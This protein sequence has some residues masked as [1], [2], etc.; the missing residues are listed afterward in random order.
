MDNTIEACSTLS[1][2][3]RDDYAQLV[4]AASMVVALH[5]AGSPEIERQLNLLEAV[6]EHQLFAIYEPYPEIA[7]QDGFVVGCRPRQ[8]Q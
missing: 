5:R 6:I 4:S 1:H 2:S 8:S 7:E 3:I